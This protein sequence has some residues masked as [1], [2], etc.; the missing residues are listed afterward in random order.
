VVF[1]VFAVWRG[2]LTGM[3]LDDRIITGAF[4]YYRLAI[5]P[6]VHFS[7]FLKVAFSKGQVFQFA[8]F[9]QRL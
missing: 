7:A 5:C 1:L 2:S 9:A 4:V 6:S 3:A 8:V